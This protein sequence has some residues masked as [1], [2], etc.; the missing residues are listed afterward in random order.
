MTHQL[1]GNEAA[2]L[3][4]VGDLRQFCFVMLKFVRPAVAKPTDRLMSLSASSA[5]RSH[6][7]QT[8]HCRRSRPPCEGLQRV[9]CCQPDSPGGQPLRVGLLT[10][11]KL[12]PAVVP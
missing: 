2:H 8:L 4:L 12:R 6:W 9:E 1:P 3:V 10:S 11:A 5:R 7:L